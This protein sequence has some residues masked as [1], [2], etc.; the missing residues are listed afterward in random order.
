MHRHILFSAAIQTRQPTECA[1]AKKEN[2]RSANPEGTRHGGEEEET[3]N[4]RRHHIGP[5]RRVHLTPRRSTLASTLVQHL[6]PI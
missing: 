3:G 5:R 2:F 4:T 1:P 6:I